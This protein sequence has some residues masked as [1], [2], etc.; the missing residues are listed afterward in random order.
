[1]GAELGDGDAEML[2]EGET[3]DDGDAL[4]DDDG[5]L[6]GTRIGPTIG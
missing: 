1:V 4:G 6:P 5:L 2:E 3:L